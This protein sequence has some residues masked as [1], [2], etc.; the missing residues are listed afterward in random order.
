[1]KLAGNGRLHW[2]AFF[3]GK[4]MR[5]TLMIAAAFA[6]PLAATPA[7]A[8]GHKEADAPKLANLDWYEINYVRYHAGKVGEA[9]AMQEVFKEIAAKAGLEMPMF[10]HMNSG[11][12]HTML[13]RKMPGGIAQMGWESNPNGQKWWAGLIERMGSE[14]KA[15]EYWQ[16]YQSL[17]ADEK[18]EI[19]H[20]DL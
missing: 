20:I 9:R 5:K 13:V 12:W 17:V 11:E 16:K 19:G 18:E 7:L 8:D 1:M 4:I 2:V 3:R 10:F 14:E 6:M 15:E